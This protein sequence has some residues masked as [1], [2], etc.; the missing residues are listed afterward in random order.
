MG[1]RGR[2]AA[3]RVYECRG[4]CV[5]ELK[6]LVEVR[7]GCNVSLRVRKTGVERNK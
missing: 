7:L 2:S 5:W 1:S 4:N 3:M 6:G